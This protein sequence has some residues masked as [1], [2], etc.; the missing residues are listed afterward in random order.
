MIPGSDRKYA[1]ADHTY[2]E[3]AIEGGRLVVGRLLV[4]S[5]E[6]AA[7]STASEVRSCDQPVCKVFS[8]QK[9]QKVWCLHFGLFPPVSFSGLPC[10]AE[11][12]QGVKMKASQ[13]I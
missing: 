4:G 13:R 6:F 1:R 8:G 5:A 10:L 9:A 12:G 3:T 11:G 2:C 7:R